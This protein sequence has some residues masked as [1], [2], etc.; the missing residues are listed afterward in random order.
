MIVLCPFF[1]PR[2]QPPKLF[3]TV[4]QPLDPVTL[5]VERPIKWP[6]AALVRFMG[7]GDADAAP[8]Q[9]GPDLPTAVALITHD[10]PRSQAG[11]S[12]SRPLDGPLLHQ[13][14]KRRRFMAFAGRQH[15]GH[16]LPIPVGAEMDFGTEAALAAAQR[17]GRWVPF[18]APAA[19]W[20]ARMTVAS[21]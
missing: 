7:N 13:A 20:W 18:F 21:T 6:R 14:L 16:G 8:P 9:V 11:S 19:C 1:I 3:E 12:P 5:P 10:S 2:R 15:D 4:D 17:F